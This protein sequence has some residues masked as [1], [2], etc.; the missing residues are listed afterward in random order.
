M[1]KPDQTTLQQ[2]SHCL[3]KTISGNKQAVFLDHDANFWER[4]VKKNK[5]LL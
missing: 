1:Q 2:T 3:L 4:I 5:H